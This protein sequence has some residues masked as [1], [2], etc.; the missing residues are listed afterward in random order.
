M[1]NYLLL[2]GLVVCVLLGHLAFSATFGVWLGGVEAR[3][4]GDP[5][6]PGR[7]KLREAAITIM[8]AICLICIAV[9]YH[10]YQVLIFDSPHVLRNFGYWYLTGFSSRMLLLYLRDEIFHPFY[11]PK[12]EEISISFL[13]ALL[14]PV[15]IPVTVYGI[16]RYRK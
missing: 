15:Q 10:I 16:W 6:E 9:G 12:W 14:G 8:G 1:Y 5:K 7:K 4:L 2:A 3:K 11:A 13:W